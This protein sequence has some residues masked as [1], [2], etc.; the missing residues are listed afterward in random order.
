MRQLVNMRLP[1]ELLGRVDS[2]CGPRGRTEFVVRALEAALVG[3]ALKGAQGEDRGVSPGRLKSD[4]SI[5][6]SP[7]GSSGVRD[8]SGDAMVPSPPVV[9]HAGSTPARPPTRSRAIDP[10]VLARQAKL[11][12][13]RYKE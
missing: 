8:E 10:A 2:V 6:A 11:N 13:A 12:K 3:L 9:A 5:P 1:V 7:Q 4:S